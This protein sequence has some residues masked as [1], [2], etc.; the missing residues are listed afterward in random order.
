M[1]IE[2]MLAEWKTDPDLPTKYGV[3]PA[4]KALIEEILI[5]GCWEHHTALEKGYITRK[6]CT[7]EDGRRS[8]YC[9][10][11]LYKGRFGDGLKVHSPN[12]NSTCL[13]WVTYWICK[14]ALNG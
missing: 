11:E 13:H 2:K 9:Y 4:P 7:T 6:E 8:S 5:P 14:E 3:R 10:V 12:H 1:N